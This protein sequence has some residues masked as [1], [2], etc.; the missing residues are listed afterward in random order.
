MS[1]LQ[2][3]RGKRILLVEA[4]YHVRDAISIYFARKGCDLL[5]FRAAEEALPAIERGEVDVII[6]SYGA[7]G[8]KWNRAHE[9]IERLHSLCGQN[10]PSDPRGRGSHRGRQRHWNS[11]LHTE[12]LRD[13][14]HRRVAFTDHR[15]KEELRRSCQFPTWIEGLGSVHFVLGTTLAVRSQ[16]RDLPQETVITHREPAPIQAK[17]WRTVKHT[18]ATTTFRKGG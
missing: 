1:P 4:D 6:I 12:A 15:Y 7:P 14:D 10:T 16:V 17:Y 18:V 9:I 2:T 8:K 13:Q 3:L 11:R 5:A